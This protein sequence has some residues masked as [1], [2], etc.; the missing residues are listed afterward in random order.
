MVN[1]K[2][3]TV[4]VKDKKNNS[5][6]IAEV[7]KEFSEAKGECSPPSSGSVSQQGSIEKVTHRLGCEMRGA[8]QPVG[9]GWWFPAK[10]TTYTKSWREA[11]TAL[12]SQ[13]PAGSSEWGH[14]QG[15]AKPAAQSHSPKMVCCHCRHTAC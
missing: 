6:I 13:G 3:K 7:Y 4:P 12:P 5:C 9:E 10:G 14:S 11:Q 2:I 15:R 8:L 1:R